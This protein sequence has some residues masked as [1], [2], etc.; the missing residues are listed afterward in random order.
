[1]K[2]KIGIIT[3]H[4]AINYGAILQAYALQTK[5]KDCGVENIILD[6]RNERLEKIHAKKTLR[7]CKTLKSLIFFFLAHKNYNRK[8]VKFRSFLNEHMTLSLPMYSVEDLVAYEDDYSLFITGSDQVW[9]YKLNGKDPAY[10]LNFV[11][12]KSKKKTYAASFGLSEIPEELKQIY[13]DLLSDF[14]SILIRENQGSKII[15]DLLSKSSSVVLDPTMLISK[16]QWIKK[17]KLEKSTY[18][19][20]DKYILVYAFAG[21]TNIKKLAINISKE[22]GYKILWISSTYKQSFRIKYIKEAGPKEFVSLFSNAE[23]VITNSF[24]GTAFSIN[25]NKQFSMELLPESSGV[26]SRLED[27]LELFGLQDRK[28]TSC[29]PDVINSEIDYKVVNEKLKIERNKSISV[30][31]DALYN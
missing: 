9:N 11:E 27:I 2:D 20:N 26:N 6:Y 31:E 13:R 8:H 1:M 18:K 14:D 19:I 30:L 4:R 10:F 5:L 12:D 25:F 17:L 29:D 7:K 21:S 24:H 22:T 28:I 16:E 23:Y 15:Q 3:Y